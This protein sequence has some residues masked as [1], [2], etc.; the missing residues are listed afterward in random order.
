MSTRK[1][2]IKSATYVT[3]GSLILPAVACTPGKKDTN[4]N[5][6]EEATV[7]KRMESGIQVYSVRNQLIEDFA[8]T[9]V[10]IAEIGYKLIEGYGLGLDGVFLGKISP[11]DYKKTV[12]DL[13]MKLVATHCSYFTSDDASKM[14]EAA[15][16][17]GIEYLIIPGIPRDNRETIDGY[18]KV[19]ENFNKIGEQCNASGLKFGY[20]NHAF[21]F[22]KLEDQIPQEVLINETEQDLVAFEAD[23]FWATKGGYDPVKLIKKFP[24]RIKLFHVKD[25]TAELGEATVGQGV[26]DF[27][28]IF[29][30]G[31]KS[32]LVYYFIEDEREDDPFANIK[33]DHDYI[34]AQDFV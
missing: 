22:E 24:G 13:G 11:E 28:A 26:I 27:K 32:G 15:H 25:A 4:E 10:K 34:V 6:A 17:A 2:F 19:A 8:D 12:T 1:E 23:L 20:H 29:E 18:K 14:I 5:N 9:M 33:A 30:A 16:K 7:P 31:K 21:E 3:A